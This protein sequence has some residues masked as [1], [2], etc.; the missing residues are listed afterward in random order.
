MR[1]YLLVLSPLLVALALVLSADV[2]AKAGVQ[3]DNCIGDPYVLVG[4]VDA[5]SAS[6]LVIWIDGSTTLRINS[7]GPTWYWEE[8][9][10][11]LPKP[12]TTVYVE[13]SEVDCL[14]DA[15]YVLMYYK[16]EPEEGQN[17]ELLLRDYDNCIPLWVMKSRQ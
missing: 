4:T 8:N 2:V 15:E 1:R 6:G 3:R 11:P 13:Y 10:V 9:Q 14:G 7:V 5:F 17:F 16:Y 12:N